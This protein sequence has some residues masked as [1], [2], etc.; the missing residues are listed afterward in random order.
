MLWDA[1]FNF[2]ELLEMSSL[3]LDVCFDIHK[4]TLVKVVINETTIMCG[5]QEG[6]PLGNFFYNLL[7]FQQGED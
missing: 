7:E 1:L 2:K 3:K 6:Y 4:Y 5:L